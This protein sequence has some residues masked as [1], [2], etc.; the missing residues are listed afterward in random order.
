[1]MLLSSGQ[2]ET[3][4]SLGAITGTIGHGNSLTLTSSGL[5]ASGP[6]V[7][8]FEDYSG[9]TNGADVT[10]SNT[11]YDAVNSF[12]VPT[13]TTDSR[14]GSLASDVYRAKNI[15]PFGENGCSTT[16]NFSNTTEVLFSFALKVPDGNRW[17]GASAEETFPTQSS[18]KVG[19]L[20]GNFVANPDED[21]LVLVTQHTGSG[22]FAIAGNDL[23]N[24][25]TLASSAPSWWR[26]DVWNRFLV[27]VKADPVDPVNNNGELYVQVTNGT[28]HATFSATPKVFGSYTTNAYWDKIN[29]MSYTLQNSST[30]KFL[31]DDVCLQINA[32]A[33]KR[34]EF[35]NAATYTA[36]TELA[37]QEVT[38]WNDT[39]VNFTCQE[40][41]LNLAQSTWWYAFDETNTLVDS[42]VAVA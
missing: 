11:G 21:D 5:G 33:A 27:W 13:F 28:D 42:G 37:L 15:S 12:W 19:W 39:T 36:C 4:A 16:M 34:V 14:S 26:W 30:G 2:V 18:L 41:G 22:G 32:N 9:G 17:P 38:S 8:L 23:G 10:T 25:L 31:L 3:P 40:G 29:L 1:M 7:E 24:L 20:G 35:G 6:T